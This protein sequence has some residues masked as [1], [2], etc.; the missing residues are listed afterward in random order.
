[1]KTLTLLSIVLLTVIPLNLLAK[2][3]Y[4]QKSICQGYGKQSSVNG[5]IK[6]AKTSGHWKGNPAKGYKYVN[7]YS[8]SK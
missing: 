4:Q 2:K 7:S 3:G 8:R 1:M 6:T 5:R